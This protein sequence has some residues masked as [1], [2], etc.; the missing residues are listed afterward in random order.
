[1]NVP[2]QLPNLLRISVTRFHRVSTKE[3]PSSFTVDSNTSPDRLASGPRRIPPVHPPESRKSSSRTI[4]A[5]FARRKRN[6]FMDAIRAN[7]RTR[8]GC[9]SQLAVNL[10]NNTRQ[11]FY[12]KLVVDPENSL[13]YSVKF[14]QR[15]HGVTRTSFGKSLKGMHRTRPKRARSV[16]RYPWQPVTVLEFS[17]GI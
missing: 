14:I 17:R 8:T 2:T 9:S 7:E 16:P 13:G 12:V 15:I 1:M 3:P 11:A 5:V 6:R 10:V 4:P